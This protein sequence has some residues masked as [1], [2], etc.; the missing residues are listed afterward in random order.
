MEVESPSL[1]C[2]FVRQLAAVLVRSEEARLCPALSFRNEHEPEWRRLLGE[3]VGLPGLD[4]GVPEHTQL[5]QISQGRRVLGSDRVAEHDHLAEISQSGG[6]QD[7]T[8]A[9]VSGWGWRTGHSVQPNLKR[10]PAAMYDMRQVPAR[11]DGNEPP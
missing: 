2:T 6:L 9:E 5:R 7:V 3:D 4:S 11:R 10:F 1:G 8:E